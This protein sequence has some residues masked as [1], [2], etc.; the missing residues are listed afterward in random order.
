MREVKESRGGREKSGR[1][2][3]TGPR[4]SL[5][6]SP[7]LSLSLSLSLSLYAVADQRLERGWPLARLVCPQV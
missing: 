3:L 1:T 7:P 4:L 2:D 6:L 5:S